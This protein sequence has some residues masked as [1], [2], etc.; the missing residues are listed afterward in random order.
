MQDATLDFEDQRL[1]RN[2]RIVD[3][4]ESQFVR[5]F[6]EIRNL[7]SQDITRNIPELDSILAR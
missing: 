7:L 2:D 5:E 4:R 1:V 3:Q 6:I